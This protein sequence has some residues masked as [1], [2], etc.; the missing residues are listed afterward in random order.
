MAGRLELNDLK[1]PFQCKP[2]SVPVTFIPHTFTAVSMAGTN[3]LSPPLLSLSPVLLF[4]Q[5]SPLHSWA[6]HNAGFSRHY[7]MN[8]TCSTLESY[9]YVPTSCYVKHLHLTAEKENNL[10][11]KPWVKLVSIRSLNWNETERKQ[12]GIS[13]YMSSPP[14]LSPLPFSFP[15]VWVKHHIFSV[16]T[17]IPIIPT[18]GASTQICAFFLIFPPHRLR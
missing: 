12:N 7:L 3:I 6:L 15:P 18:G 8:G 14:S 16:P 2:F 17:Q 1:D 5:T 13:A 4:Y 11:S 9:P 10:H